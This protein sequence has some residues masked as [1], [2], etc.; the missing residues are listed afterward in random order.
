MRSCEIA[1]VVSDIAAFRGRSFG[2]RDLVAVSEGIDPGEAAVAGSTGRVSPSRTFTFEV[3]FETLGGAEIGCCGLHCAVA[4]A[5]D[6]GSAVRE[7]SRR[8]VMFPGGG[9]LSGRVCGR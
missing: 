7:V 6:G 3:A 5:V 8:P 2:R 1:A 9:K 4:S